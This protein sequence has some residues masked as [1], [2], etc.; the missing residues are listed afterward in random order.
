MESIGKDCQNLKNEYDACF[1]TWF[2]DK[3]LKGNYNDACADIFKRYQACVKVS[4][5]FLLQNYS[6]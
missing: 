2:S 4:I 6:F 5:F 1:N 3:F